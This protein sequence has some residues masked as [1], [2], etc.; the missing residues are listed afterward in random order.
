MLNEKI[1]K[2]YQDLRKK[3]EEL[4]ETNSLLEREKLISSNTI[5]HLTGTKNK[6]MLDVSD[7]NSKLETVIKKLNNK[8]EQERINQEKSHNSLINS[9]EN[10]HK[11]SLDELKNTINK[12]NNDILESNKYLDK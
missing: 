4:Y 1:E 12:L 7:S 6:L 8:Y 2:L 9:I 3:E 5:N 10:K 11:E